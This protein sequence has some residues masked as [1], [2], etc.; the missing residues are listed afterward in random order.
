MTWVSEFIRRGGVT[1][2]TEALRAF[3]YRS[4]GKFT[5]F[6]QMTA[7]WTCNPPWLLRWLEFS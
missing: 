2:I 7:L 4:V 5:N 3:A 1:R 6:R